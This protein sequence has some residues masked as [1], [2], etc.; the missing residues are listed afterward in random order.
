MALDP[1]GEAYFE[2]IK[3]QTGGDFPVF[4]GDRYVQYGQGFGDVLRGI[5]RHV[6]PVAVRGALTFLTEMGKKKE[7]G[8]TW[9]DAAKSALTPTALNALSETKDQI[10]KAHQAGSGRRRKRSKRV[11]KGHSKKQNLIIAEKDP[12]NFKY[13]F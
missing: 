4:Q 8:V 12:L 5:F 11:Y 10:E 2:V 9:K 1:I 3:A 6:I 13:N 7:T